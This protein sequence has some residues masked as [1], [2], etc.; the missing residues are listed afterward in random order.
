MWVGSS[1][2]EDLAT[3]FQE[4]PHLTK[5]NLYRLRY[6]SQSNFASFCQISAFTTIRSISLHSFNIYIA[7]SYQVAAAF[8]ITGAENKG[9]F[10]SV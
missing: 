9:T 6:T 2:E 10:R 1:L 7:I 5:D 4:V 3:C 8:S